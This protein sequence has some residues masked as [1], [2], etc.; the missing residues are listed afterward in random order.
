MLGTLDAADAVGVEH[1][2]AGHDPEEG[3]PG[4][5]RGEPDPLGR[6]AHPA[7][8]HEGHAEHGGA[9]PGGVYVGRPQALLHGH[10]ANGAV[11]C[12]PNRRGVYINT[13]KDA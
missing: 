1:E 11:Q 10:L 7:V 4:D 5:L 3:G 13:V 12:P 2:V 9:H 6:S 8:D